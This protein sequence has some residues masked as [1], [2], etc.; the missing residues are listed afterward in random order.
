MQK[1]MTIDIIQIT[2]RDILE[3]LNDE[4]KISGKMK[5]L[6]HKSSWYLFRHQ[7]GNNE[8]KSGGDLHAPIVLKIVV[9]NADVYW[10]FNVT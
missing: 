6:N 5:Q 2:Y 7:T 3:I 9:Y 8:K 10:T 1:V 4:T